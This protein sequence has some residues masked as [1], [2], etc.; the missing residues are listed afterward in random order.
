MFHIPVLNLIYE[1]GAI[2]NLIA[3]Y[4]DKHDNN[5]ILSLVGNLAPLSLHQIVSGATL[6]MQMQRELLW[7]KVYNNSNQFIVNG[8]FYIYTCI[9]LP[10]IW[11]NCNSSFANDISLL[12]HNSLKF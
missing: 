5:N 7:F 6:Q 9:S 11:V 3:T 2:K 4:K 12:Y 10:F 1:I 8:L